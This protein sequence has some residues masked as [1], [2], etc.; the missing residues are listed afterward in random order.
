MSAKRR[1][2]P[3]LQ[4][5]GLAHAGPAPSAL[6]QSGIGQSENAA[7]QD[8]TDRTTEQSSPEDRTRASAV[9]FLA[10]CFVGALCMPLSYTIA[11]I[12]LPIYRMVL[13]TLFVPMLV[14]LF[15]DK[16]NR[17][18]A[19]D[20]FVIL[21]CAWATI[22]LIYHH[23]AAAIETAGVTLVDGLAAYLVGR[24]LITSKSDMHLVLRYGFAFLVL[25]IPTVLI[26]A[27]TGRNIVLQFFS[28][29]GDAHS[30]TDQGIRMGLHRVQGP[31]EHPIL[32]GVFSGSLFVLAALGKAFNSLFLTILFTAT[33]MTCAL[34]SLSTGALLL[35]N[36]SLILMLWRRMFIGYAHRWKLLGGCASA[37]Y[38]FIDIV[39]NRTPFH[40]F[41][42]YLTFNSGSAYNRINIWI[43]GT[44]EVE[45]HPILG[46]GMNDWTRPSWMSPSIDNFWL[47]QAIRYG[48]P[49]FVLLSIAIYF[50]LRQVSQP[51]QLSSET[52]SLRRAMVFTLVS[53][54]FAVCSVHLWNATHSWFMFL[55]GAMSWIGLTDHTATT[56]TNS[57]SSA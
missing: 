46:I 44:A 20:A 5:G 30:N 8:E 50:A 25:L 13:I 21:Y 24:T 47:L 51:T 34:L 4:L 56:K 52:A 57:A 42:S 3:H 37:A 2:L 55:I 11:G 41:V 54:L 14:R 1:N 10:V 9:A 17:F 27:L 22:A 35:V 31:F 36:V 45:L 33:A 15:S 48:I 28:A 49:A 38:L 7:L 39:S 12:R 32:F 53:I 6:N 18:L 23:G 19:A 29:F 16:N 43:H 26:E 40:V